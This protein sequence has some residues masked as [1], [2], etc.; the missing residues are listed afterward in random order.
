[1]KPSPPAPETATASSAL[2]R[3]RMG[4][5]TMKGVVVHGKRA[6]RAFAKFNERDAMLKNGFKIKW[7][8]RFNGVPFMYVL[9][10]VPAKG[11]IWGSYLSFDVMYVPRLTSDR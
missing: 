7:L 1:M 6:A 10:L 11:Y 2:E 5:E 4:A 9:C 3:P 8:D